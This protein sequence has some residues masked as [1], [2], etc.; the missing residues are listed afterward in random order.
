[1]PVATGSINPFDPNYLNNEKDDVYQVFGMAKKLTSDPFFQALVEQIHLESNKVIYLV[2]KIG[3][4][5]IRFGKWNEVDERFERLKVYYQEILPHTGW[6]KYDFIDVQFEG[7]VVC[8][9]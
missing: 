4:S 2:P 7:Q 6:N 1:M 9:K 3:S 8:Q 5:K